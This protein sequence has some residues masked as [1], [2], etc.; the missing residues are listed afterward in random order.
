MKAIST[1]IFVAAMFAA[2][3]IVQ[4]QAKTHS[5]SVVVE[6]PS[7]LPEMAQRNSE[8]MYLHHASNGRTL[9]YLEQNEGRT[10]AILDV[11]DPATIRAV[12]QV[13][14][15]ARGPYD[16][17]RAASDSAALIEYRDHS[18]F[19]VVNFKKYKNPVLVETPQWQYPANAEVL[20][21]D[22][23]L[24]AS[25][26]VPSTPPQD[27]Q[28]EVVGVSNPTKPETLATIRGVQERLERRDT[29]TLFLL[30][31]DGLTVVRR[32]FVEEDYK[33]Q[34]AHQMQP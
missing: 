4:A 17:V 13:S 12:G 14:V 7:D 1:R 3:L 32:P 21:R 2:T 25:T 22:S 11:T 19:A 28:Y 8:A 9:L 33:I 27:P 18:G 26:S 6:S 30:G 15:A 20:G 29:G 24:L 34:Q 10:L 31:N 23:L 5:N 16:F